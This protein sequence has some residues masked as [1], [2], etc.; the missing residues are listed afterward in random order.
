MIY[1]GYHWIST[2]RKPNPKPNPIGFWALNPKTMDEKLP[3]KPK[4]LDPKPADIRTK[5]DPLPS[6]ML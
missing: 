1:F 4:P 6:L 5:T 2:G 3:P